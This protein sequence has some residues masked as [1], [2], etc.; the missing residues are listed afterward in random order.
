MD[1][2]ASYA[3]IRCIIGASMGALAYFKKQGTDW[4]LV[5]IIT[6]WAI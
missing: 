6:T 1:R 5:K 3:V 2:N 4:V